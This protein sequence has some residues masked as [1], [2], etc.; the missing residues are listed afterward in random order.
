MPFK[1]DFMLIRFRVNNFASIRTEQE[2]SFVAASWLKESRDSVFPVDGEIEALP[3]AAIYGAN[4]SGKSNVL[5]AFG[6]VASAIKDSQRAWGPTAGIPRIPF[7]LDAQLPSR[8]E[9]DLFLDGTMFQYG[10]VCDS[11][12]FLEEWLFAFP[13]KRKQEWFVRSG[14]EFKFGDFL[15]G[16]NATIAALCR[17]NSLFV[18]AAAQNGHD[19]LLPIYSWFADRFLT[20]STKNRTG[21]LTRRTSAFIDEHPEQ[22]PQLQRLL[23]AADLGLSSIVI[24]KREIDEITL[25]LETSV[26]FFIDALAEK[27]KAEITTEISPILVS[28]V[29]TLKNGDQFALRLQEESD[30][31]QA[32]FGILGTILEVLAEGYTLFID[33]LDASLHPLLCVEIGRLFGNKATNPKGAQFVFTTHDTTL[34]SQAGFRRDQVWFTEK[35]ESGGTHLYPLTDFKPR[36]TENLE[37]GYLQGRYGAIPIVGDLQ[38]A[39]AGT[40]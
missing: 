23:L 14:Q 8:F 4:A 7:K 15:K 26:A 29:H 34:L 35:D 2:F 32:Y 33:E 9:T 10:F 28:L 11:E 5:K 1:G 38:E 39:L 20:F 17:P 37:R 3:C 22:V 36:N 16:E 21:I 30:G 18:S 19:M 13:N 25:A 40:N 27:Y 31:T 12:R 24:G 6:F